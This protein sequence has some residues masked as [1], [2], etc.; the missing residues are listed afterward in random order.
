MK[1]IALK[2]N[3]LKELSAILPFIA[4]CCTILNLTD[5]AMT[6]FYIETEKHHL[7]VLKYLALI[8]ALLG[9]NRES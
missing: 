3:F 4:T 8:I 6:Y 5:F 7:K 1:L 9:Y 2:D